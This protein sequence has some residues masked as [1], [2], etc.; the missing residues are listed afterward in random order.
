MEI[1]LNDLKF[2]LRGLR[3]SPTFAITAIVTLALGIGANSA[4]FTV[5][6]AVLLQ[7]LP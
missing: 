2:A 7:P 6:N 5:I 3:K 1:L 4:V